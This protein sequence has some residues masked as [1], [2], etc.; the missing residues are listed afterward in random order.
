MGFDRSSRIGFV[1]A[2]KVGTTLAVALHRQD[3]PVVAVASRTHA[4]AR[5]LG[6]RVPGCKAYESI[7]EAADACDVVFITTT[8]DVIESVTDSISWRADQAAIHCSG[9]ASLDVLESAKRQ[10]AAHP[11]QAFASVEAALE[12][13]PGTTYAIEGDG[14]LKT[15]LEEMAAVLGGRPILLRSED[16]ALYHA[17]VVLLGGILLGYGG[18]VADLWRHMGLDAPMASRASYRS[19]RG[20]YRRCGRW[21]CQ[22]PWPDPSCAVTRAR[23]VS[24]STR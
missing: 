10:G 12:S 24:T 11:L 8:D 6:E 14:D 15:Y 7:Q 5:G 17:S 19:C 23:F 1:G 16:K 13:L 4:S 18:A 20:A 2:G 22:R 9:A 21:E 3:Y